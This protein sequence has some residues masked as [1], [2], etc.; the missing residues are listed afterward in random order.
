MKKGGGKIWTM[1]SS[2]LILA[3]GLK[4][5]YSTASVNDLLWVLAPT[6]LLVELAT[7]ETFRFESYA[8]YMNA[9]HSFLIAASC[10]GVNFFITAFLMLALVPLFK[11]RKENVRYVELPVALLAAYVATILANAVRI[12]VALRLQRMNADLIWVNPEQL[13]RFEGIFIY[14]GFLLIL[15]VVSEG[16]RGNYE[17]RS[18]DYLLSLKRIALPLAIYWGTTLGIP[19]AN[20][21]YR[22]GTVFWEH[23]LFVLLTPLVLLLPLSIFRLLKATNK[24][25]GVYG[26]IRSIH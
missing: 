17:S 2:A 22:Q 14:F 11:R 24:T 6:K 23:C 3:A 26:V 16:F 1:G 20:G 25:V 8:G 18:S 4:L 7:G 10:S 5:Y 21:A 12:C 15:F 9:D 13:H 19:L